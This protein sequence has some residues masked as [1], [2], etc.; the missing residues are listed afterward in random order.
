MNQFMIVLNL[1][2]Y[3][4]SIKNA[5]F[6]TDVASEVVEETGL[7]IIVCP[8]AL[9]LKGAADRFSDVFAQH[10]DPEKPGAYT[11]SIPAEL[12][13][14]VGVKGSLV[15]HSEKRISVDKIK[16]AL[17]SLHT[18]QLDSIV[19]AASSKEAVEFAVFSPV[20]IAVEPPELIGSGISVSTAN[21]DIVI[22]TVKA[23]KETNSKV[24]VLCGAGVSN[25]ND[26]KKSLELGAE[27]VLL[28][29]A[30]VKAE[31]PK[32]FLNELASVF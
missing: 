18:A 4:L 31:D 22:N 14:E 24:G 25:K 29:S 5:L 26:V 17:D 10:V 7:R 3:E 2:T 1:K 6:F 13:R 30:F 32:K 8:P 11:G 19:C 20:F 27:G 28:A 21:P 9:H 16:L 12:L 15:N 23:V